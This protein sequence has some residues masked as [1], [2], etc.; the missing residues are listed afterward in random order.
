MDKGQESTS[1]TGDKEAM[2]ILKA[3]LPDDAP[4]A[5]S[6]QES[7]TC[8][9][10]E[11]HLLAAGQSEKKQAEGDESGEEGAVMALRELNAKLEQDNEMLRKAIKQRK[12]AISKVDAERDALRRLKNRVLNT[13]RS[14]VEEGLELDKIV[15]G[16]VA[17]SSGPNVPPSSVF[18]Q[19]EEGIDSSVILVV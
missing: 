11:G 16:S 4:D 6:S 10:S 13:E 9:D 3:E 1:Q 14:E 17:Q 5:D 19:L 8:T 12:A 15:E 2:G 7:E 18:R